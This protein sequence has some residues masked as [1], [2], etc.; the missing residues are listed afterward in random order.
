MF[1]SDLS[2]S[3]KGVLAAS[4]MQL[5][6]I[7]NRIKYSKG[8]S[9]VKEYIIRTYINSQ[10]SQKNKIILKKFSHNS[11]EDSLNR[12]QKNSPQVSKHSTLTKNLSRT[13]HFAIDDN[14]LRQRQ[15]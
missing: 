3:G 5:T 15:G 13:F 6:K 11:V 2:F 8:L 10:I 7:V 12:G 4:K 1:R 14:K 9:S